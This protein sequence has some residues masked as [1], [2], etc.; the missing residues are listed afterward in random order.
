MEQGAGRVD[1]GAAGRLPCSL[2]EAVAVKEGCHGVCMCQ[3]GQLEVRVVQGGRGSR[4]SRLAAQVPVG[5]LL[6]AG[7]GRSRWRIGRKSRCAV[8]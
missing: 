5:K 4:D 7:R 3:S 1:F 8:S 2:H 6:V